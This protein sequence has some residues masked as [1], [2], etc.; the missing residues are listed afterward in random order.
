MEIFS[1]VFRCPH[2][3]YVPPELTLSHFSFNSP[4]GACPHCHGLG[5]L[6]SFTE[7]SVI[8]PDKTLEDGAVLPWGQDSYY[9]FVL[10]GA[11]KHLKIPVNI[12]YNALKKEHKELILNG[13]DARL[14][15]STPQMQKPWNA[16]YPGILPYLN[17]VYHD[18]ET[19]DALHEKIDPFVISTICPTCHGYRVGEQARHVLITS[20][21]QKE[22][23]EEKNN[24]AQSTK[25]KEGS[26]GS[27]NEL[28]PVVTYHIGQLAELSVEA[29]V[30][31]FHALQLSSEDTK[32]ATNMVKNITDRLKFLQGVGLGY[33]TLARRS[34][35]LSGGES[36]RIRLATQVGTKLEG[37]TYVLD[38]PS[39]GLHPRDSRLLIDNL[40]EL[41]NLGNT[42]I[43]VEHDEE[44]MWQSD[45]II[46]IGP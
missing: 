10:M 28:N 4:A 14:S 37:I 8:D 32:V 9:H 5:S 43:V 24:K 34:N 15:L 23:R 11:C 3:G 21:M 35:T 1:R 17:R 31:F 36:Q 26:V 45:Q 20:K 25:Q 13:S 38:E 39:I 30:K 46:D 22:A 29:S 16:K 40:R 7:A 6:L 44:V 42:V 27:D 18:P 2:C 19:S 12:V 41:V 33:M